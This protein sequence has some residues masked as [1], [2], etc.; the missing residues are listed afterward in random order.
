MSWSEE[1][2]ALAARIDGLLCAVELMTAAL[3]VHS[4]DESN[5]FKKSLEPALSE[6]IANLKHLASVY[7]NELPE[8][9]REALSKF[10][11]LRT[12]EGISSDAIG[13]QRFVHLASFRS[14]LEYLLRDLETERRSLTELAFEHLRRQ[15]VVDTDIKNKWQVAF[16]SNEVACER[17]GAVHLLGHGIWAF[18]VSAPGS[19]TDLVFG[20]PIPQDD[21]QLKRTARALVLTEWK[22]IVNVGDMEAKAEE[23]REQTKIYSGGVMGDVELKQTRYIVLVSESDWAPP[24]DLIDG[25]ITY[26]H[27]ILPVKSEVPS[28]AARSKTTR[29]RNH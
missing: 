5:V 24:N 3:A 4:R 19:A 13:I 1:W 12:N 25:R 21:K 14:E 29:P 16:R 28:R 27:I 6:I 2:R 15:L 17:L 23:A 7:A 26:R 11:G 9:A 18:K 8:N 10:I 22:R 20:D